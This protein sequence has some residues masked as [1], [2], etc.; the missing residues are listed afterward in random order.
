[1]IIILRHCQR[2]GVRVKLASTQFQLFGH[3]YSKFGTDDHL[4]NWKSLICAGGVQV[5]LQTCCRNVIWSAYMH[6]G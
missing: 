4:F 3:K 5:L 1:M 2:D 6:L